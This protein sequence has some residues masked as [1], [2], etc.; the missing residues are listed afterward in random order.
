MFLNLIG[1]AVLWATFVTVLS[2]FISLYLLRFF[3]LP[4]KNVREQIED[5][6]N[7]AVGA[8]FFIIS[9]ITAF[10][11]SVLSAGTPTFAEP[12]ETFFWIF[13]GLVFAS[14]Y[15]MGSWWIAHRRFKPTPGETLYG[16]IKRELIEEQN[17][18]LALFLGG[19][20]VPPFIAVLYQIY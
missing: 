3:G 19:L 11:C 4:L 14:V 13:G 12:L 6:Q 5:V 15:T 8:F 16:W 2:Q 20:A 7:P 1:S 10:W 9:L 17:I 18:A